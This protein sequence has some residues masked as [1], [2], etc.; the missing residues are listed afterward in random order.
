MSVN[1]CDSNSLS[2]IVMQLMNIFVQE[3]CVKQSVSNAEPDVL[4]VDT[5]SKLPSQ[6]RDTWKLFLGDLVINLMSDGT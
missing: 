3:R 5:E 2:V 6:F 4:Y 1:C